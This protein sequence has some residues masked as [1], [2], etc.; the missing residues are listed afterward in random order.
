LRARLT[1]MWPRHIE[2]LPFMINLPYPVRFYKYTPFSIQDNCIVSPRGFEKFVN[3]LDILL[4]LCIS[5]IV[6]SLISDEI[7]LVK[8]A[9]IQVAAL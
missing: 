2:V 4:G 8:S 9:V 1:N 7:C 3:H 6:L 5:L